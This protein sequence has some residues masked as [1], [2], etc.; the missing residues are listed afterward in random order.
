MREAVDGHE[1]VYWYEADGRLAS[2]SDDLG[3]RWA[4][5]YDDAGNL[6]EKQLLATHGEGP[7]TRITYLYDC[8]Q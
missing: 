1:T 4:Y 5:R 7:L 2:E 3:I 8:W 6:I